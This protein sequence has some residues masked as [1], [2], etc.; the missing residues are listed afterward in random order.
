M[1]L[2]QTSDALAKPR[3]SEAALID[4]PEAAVNM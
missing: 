1:S 4:D 3:V 2:H